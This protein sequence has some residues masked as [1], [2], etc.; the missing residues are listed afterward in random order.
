[1]WLHPPPHI[2]IIGIINAIPSTG[3]NRMAPRAINSV[4]ESDSF[5]VMGGLVVLW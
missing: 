5:W 3:R 4:P 2:P 1:M